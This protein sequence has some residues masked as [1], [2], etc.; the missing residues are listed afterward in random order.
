MKSIKVYRAAFELIHA[1]KLD[2]S[3]IIFGLV[4]ENA[5]TFGDSTWFTD[6]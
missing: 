4:V 2:S 6:N 1:M 5:L 3:M